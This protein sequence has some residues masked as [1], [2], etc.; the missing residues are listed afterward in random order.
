MLLDLRQRELLRLIWRE[1]RLSR[2]EL[3]E[4]TG[5]NPNAIGSEAAALLQLG[6]LREASPES[7]GQGRPRTPLE[8]DTATRHVIGLS[9]YPGQV[10]I[11][12]LNLRGQLLGKPTS[13]PAETPLET[14]QIAQRLLKQNLKVQ[15]LA[16]G[17]SCTGFLDPVNK[18]LLFS[19]ITRTPQ[20][21]P[22]DGIVEAAGDKPIVFE[23]DMHALAVRWLLT[24]LAEE[25]EDVLLVYIGDGRLGAAMLID[26]RPNRG[27]LTGANELGHT[28]LPVETEKCY[29]GQRGCLERICS[30]P[31]LQ[32]HAGVNGTGNDNG[33]HIEGTLLERAARY[34]PD[35]QPLR[36]LINLLAMGLSNAVNFMRPNRLVVVS[37]L[38]RYPEF[39]DNLLRQVRTGLLFEL[40]NRVRIDLWDQPGAV[41]AESA[42]WLALAGLYQEGWN[43]L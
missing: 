2:W 27:C 35:D 15:S 10:E 37:E 42:G 28:R 16:V 9:L 3:H 33:Q 18:A 30:T 38:T 21:Q 24:H 34:S 22:L 17:I 40:V 19:S 39:C 12:K 23:N 6:I 25:K 20:P 5:V 14:V 1:N 8:I 36:E 43:S 41:S 26:G 13:G 29:C 31:F 11:A 4:R 7:V 32:K